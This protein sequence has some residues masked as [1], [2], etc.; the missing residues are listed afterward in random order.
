MSE[1]QSI[2]L[3]D[4]DHEFRDGIRRMFEESGYTVAIACDGQ[5]AIDILSKDAFDLVVS[6]LRLP[7]LNGIE[8]MK[9]IS[10][11]RMNVSVIFLTAYGEIESYMDLMNM[12]AFD[13]LNKPVREKEI[14]SVV[15]KAI[16]ALHASHFSGP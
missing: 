10:R 9:E 1:K 12:G 14:L 5:E 7:G 6:E 13:Y 16:E 15:K 11:K 4:D 2:L 3:V 8:L